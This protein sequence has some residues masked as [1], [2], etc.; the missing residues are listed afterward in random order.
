MSER[1]IAQPSATVVLLRDAP[2]PE[3]GIEVLLGQRG[4]AL[5]FHGGEWV[6]PGGRVDPEDCAHGHA[7]DSLE[8]ARCAAVRECM[9]EVGVAVSLSALSAW[10]HWT[11]PLERRK[12][13]AAWFFLAPYEGGE[14]RVDGVEMESC[15][16]MRPSEALAAQASGAI[17][18][19]PPTFVTLAELLPFARVADVFAAARVRELPFILPNPLAVPEGVVS[20]YPGDAG[21]ASGQLDHDG[22]QHRLSMLASGWRYV[23]ELG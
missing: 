17:G 3:G 10:S 22:P 20:L 23:C 21:Y 18:L 2:L 7:L 4:A 15:R 19:P 9:E 12:R 6:F 1:A 16:F 8:A 5:D 11:T 14:L 13:F